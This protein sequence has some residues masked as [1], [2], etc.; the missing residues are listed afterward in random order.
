M[1]LLALLLGSVSFLAVSACTGSTCEAIGGECVGNIEPC[2]DGMRP[3][4][5]GGCGTGVCCLPAVDAG[6]ADSGTGSTTADAGT[7]DGGN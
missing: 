6:T 3:A 2:S 7:A 1:R 4:L 5:G